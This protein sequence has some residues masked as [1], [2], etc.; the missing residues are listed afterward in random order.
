MFPIHNDVG[1]EV[2]RIIVLK[3]VRA[4]NQPMPSLPTTKEMMRSMMMHQLWQ[5]HTIDEV[6][7]GRCGPQIQRC[8]NDV[9][10]ELGQMSEREMQEQITIRMRSKPHKTLSTPLLYSR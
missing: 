2:A 10:T 3:M 6:N 7:E 1:L 5:K 8:L 9:I 4:L